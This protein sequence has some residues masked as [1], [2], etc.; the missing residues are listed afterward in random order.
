M[1]ERLKALSDP[2]RAPGPRSFSSD[3]E[4]VLPMIANNPLLALAAIPDHL[5]AIAHLDLRDGEDRWQ[6]S[7][8]ADHQPVLAALLACPNAPQWMAEFE[9]HSGSPC[10]PVRAAPANNPLLVIERLRGRVLR[11]QERLNQLDEESARCV[12]VLRPQINNHL[13]ELQ[14]HCDTIHFALRGHPDA[15]PWQHE[16]TEYEREQHAPEQNARDRKTFTTLV[17]AIAARQREWDRN[18]RLTPLYHALELGGEIGELLN[19]IKK[20]ERLR[21]GLA[22]STATDEQLVEELADVLICTH[23]LANALGIDV[24]REARRKFNLRSEELGFATRVEV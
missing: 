5:E 23:L 12:C 10:T 4:S 21:L 14:D 24:E 15:K 1:N 2:K 16:L 11:Y 6:L 18:G 17:E 3:L 8:G 13:N 9:Q 22:G 7:L 19:V 20:Q